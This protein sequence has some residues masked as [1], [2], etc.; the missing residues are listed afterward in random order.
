MDLV[1]KLLDGTR[2]DTASALAFL[3]VAAPPAEAEAEEDEE[4][5]RVRS[6]S[7]EVAEPW[8]LSWAVSMA[9]A[10][11]ASAI[12]RNNAFDL[13]AI[14]LAVNSHSISTRTRCKDCA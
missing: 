1:K 3:P 12:D 7:E 8:R 4:G 2:L 5:G 10:E 14:S 13:G 6:A 9:L 11:S